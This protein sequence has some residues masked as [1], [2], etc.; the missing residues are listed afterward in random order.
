[1]PTMSTL[2]AGA[3]P[4]PVT[5]QA[6]PDA[7]GVVPMGAPRKVVQP[8]DNTFMMSP[9]NGRREY[10]KRIAGRDARVCVHC[11]TRL[12]PWHCTVC[13]SDLCDV[14]VRL[15]QCG[16]STLVK[17]RAHTLTQIRE[18][19]LL[20]TQPKS[21]CN[22]CGCTPLTVPY[23]H[24]MVCVDY[25]LCE[26]CDA[27]NDLLIKNLQSIHDSGHPMIKFRKPPE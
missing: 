16:S 20:T 5:H 21:F 18:R 14:C 6:A 25:D 12:V 13:G 1:M 9:I 26:G 22:A 24:C 15:S 7:E 2:F 10:E 3:I 23:F 19:K 4:G 11:T 17:G 8:P 27:A